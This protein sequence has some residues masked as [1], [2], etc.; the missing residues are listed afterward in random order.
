MLAKLRNT[1]IG[2]AESPEIKEALET[3]FMS[4]GG[5]KFLKEITTPVLVV[6][7]GVVMARG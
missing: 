2:R 7:F 6:G 5:Q 1:G 4:N 3:Q